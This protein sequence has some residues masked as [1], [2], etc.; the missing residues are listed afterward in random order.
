MMR[1]PGLSAPRTAVQRSFF[2]IAL[3]VAAIL[4]SPAPAPAQPVAPSQVTPP[5]LRPPPSPPGGNLVLPQTPTLQ[6]PQGAENLDVVVGDVQVD[7]GFPELAA[8]TRDLEGGIRGKQVTVA[9]LYQFANELEHAYDQAGYPLVRVAVP[10]QQLLNEGSFRVLIVDGFI[11]AIDVEGVPDRVRSVIAARLQSLLFRRH[12][13]L[14]QI[15]RGLLIAGDIPGV[16]LRSAL[17]PGTSDGG[18]RLIVEGDH[19]LV[20]GSLGLD[21]R[22]PTSLGTRQLTAKTAVNSALGFGEQVYATLGYGAAI[23]PSL[24]GSTPYEVYGGGVVLPVG[25]DGITVNPEYIHSRSQTLPAPHTISSAGDFDHYALNVSDPLVR[26]RAT[27]LYAN[28]SLEEIIQKSYV[29][30]PATDLSLDHYTVVRLGPDYSTSLLQ[31]KDLEIKVT[32]SQG[33]AGRGARQA[34]ASGLGLSTSGAI[35]GFTKATANL[36]L[37]EFLS[38]D[39]RLDVIAHGQSSFGRPMFKAEQYSLTEIDEVSAF[40]DGVINVD[41][42]GTLRI[43]LSHPFVR[44]FDAVDL[45]LAPYLFGAAGRGGIVNATPLEQRVTN[46][47]AIGIGIRSAAQTRATPLNALL[48]AELARQ[49]TDLAGFRQGWQA[50]FRVVLGF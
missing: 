45:P 12:V 8:A 48:N 30:N 40:A 6:A 38:R 7:G 33:L 39:V 34:S 24:P 50:N 20:T 41:Q 13:T 18:T 44:S 19:R 43:E 27:D 49:F 14:T 10:P 46:A 25:P 17:S 28:G 37:T 11:E 29:P 1:L 15:E 22:L 3:S 36:Q 23:T 9:R 5:T 35:P 32:A 2:P 47:Q 42:G 31:D 21:N 4:I 26:S 16:S